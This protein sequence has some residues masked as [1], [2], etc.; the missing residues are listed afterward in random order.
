MF[1]FSEKDIIDGMIRPIQN[2][3]HKN[4][5]IFLNSIMILQNSKN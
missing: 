3:N 4:P 1:V 2:S 5:R